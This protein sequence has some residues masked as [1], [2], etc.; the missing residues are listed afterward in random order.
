M[1]FTTWNF[2]LFLAVVLA[3]FYSAPRAARRYIL[4][5]ASFYF[6]MCWNPR[7]VLLLLTLIT[8]DYFAAIWIESRTGARR[9]AALLLSL[10]ANLGFLAWFKYTNFLLSIF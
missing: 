2:W 7:F 8:V 4:L 5:A 3:A 1:L 10:V 6:Y 9:H